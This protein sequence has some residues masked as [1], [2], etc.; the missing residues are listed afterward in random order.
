M[1][2]TSYSHELITV[3]VIAVCVQTRENFTP[4]GSRISGRR[5]S[6]QVRSRIE[7]QRRSFPSLAL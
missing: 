5:L 4:S 6:Q 7:E 1:V 2:T 3:N